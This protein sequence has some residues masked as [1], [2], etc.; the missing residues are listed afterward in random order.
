MGTTKSKSPNPGSKNKN[1][2]REL[3]DSNYDIDQEATF[4]SRLAEVEQI[5]HP[6]RFSALKSFYGVIS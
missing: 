2:Y 1:D 4:F 5:K 3:S 6:V